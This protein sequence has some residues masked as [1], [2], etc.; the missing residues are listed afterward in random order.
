MIE[1]F[2]DYISTGLLILL[3]GT[4]LVLIG[5]LFFRHRK[6]RLIEEEIEYYQEW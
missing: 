5:R 3:L 2:S 4:V 6:Q 1:S